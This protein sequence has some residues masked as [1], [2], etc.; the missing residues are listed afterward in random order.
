M[1]HIHP[2]AVQRPTH[3]RLHVRDMNDAHVVLEAVRMHKL[4]PVTRR[5]N[6][7]ERMSY[8]RSGSVFVWEESDDDTG[9]RR[10]T[11]GLLW[12]ASRM[13]EVCSSPSSM[14]I[15]QHNSIFICSFHSL[16]CF[17]KQEPSTLVILHQTSQG[18]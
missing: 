18:S 1:L 15:D 16:S 11:D 7:V 9:L 5:L 17:M 6:E 8:I 4:Q 12:S 10:W 14:S 2:H 13:R 3:S